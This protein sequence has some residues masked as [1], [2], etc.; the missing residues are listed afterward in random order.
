[1]EY[2][3]YLTNVTH[4]CHRIE[5]IHITGIVDILDIFEHVWTILLIVIVFLTRLITEV[6]IKNHS[7]PHIDMFHASDCY[8]LTP[9]QCVF[10]LID[11]YR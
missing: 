9:R 4:Q 10:V 1:M 6:N 5:R 8:L 11:Q 7:N 3:H 2:K